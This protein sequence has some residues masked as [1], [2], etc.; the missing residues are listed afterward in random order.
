[1]AGA[2]RG[3]WQLLLA[4]ALVA[5]FSGCIA[6]SG[7][8]PT[9]LTALEAV[10]HA[11]RIEDIPGPAQAVHAA[12]VGTLGMSN[13]GH[14]ITQQGQAAL[15]LI[16]LEAPNATVSWSVLVPAGGEP[17]V[18]QQPGPNTSRDPLPDGLLDSDRALQ[19][20]A[21]EQGFGPIQA[22]GMGISMDLEVDPE[23]GPVW[24]ILAWTEQDQRVVQVDARTG[25][26]L[27]TPPP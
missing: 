5:P 2:D 12:T 8:G 27:R 21:G 19:L 3:R 14:A 25:H 10:E 16:T 22:P 4:L 26:I 9:G 7:D 24:R 17:E 20:A 13:R 11:E 23:A 6:F 1:M 15:W 18:H